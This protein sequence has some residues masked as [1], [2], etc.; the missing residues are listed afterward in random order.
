MLTFIT[1]SALFGYF[2]S[3]ILKSSGHISNKH[4]QISVTVKSCEEAKMAKCGAKSA[5]FEYFWP[6][7]CQPPIV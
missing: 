2:F 6:K 4:L 5:L 1:K 3:R 7:D